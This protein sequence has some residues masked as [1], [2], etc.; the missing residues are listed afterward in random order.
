MEEDSVVNQSN[1]KTAMD[2]TTLIVRIQEFLEKNYYAP[3]L[4]KVR[5]G[6]KSMSIEFSILAIYDPELADYLLDKSL[7]G[8]AAFP[9]NRAELLLRFR[10]DENVSV[11]RHCSALPSFDVPIVSRNRYPVNR[12]NS[13]SCAILVQRCISFDRLA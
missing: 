13:E 9:R 7:E 8:L 5:K 4:D 10:F 12:Q 6:E 11:S 3:L 2:A 1:E